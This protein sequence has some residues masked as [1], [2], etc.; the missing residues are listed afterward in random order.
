MIETVLALAPVGLVIAIGRS[1]K[2]WHFPGDGFWAP[3]ERIAYYI[4]MPSLIVGN[5]TAAPLGD[6]DIAPI[7]LIIMGSLLVGAA[8]MLALRRFL[9]LDGPAYTSLF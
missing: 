9:T 3:A 7:V 1:L 2:H 8:V 6:L 5:L 4:L